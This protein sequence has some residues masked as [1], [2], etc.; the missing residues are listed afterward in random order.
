MNDLN[1][2]KNNEDGYGILIERDAGY[3]TREINN[4]NKILTESFEYNPEEPIL[5]NCILQKYG[6]PNRNGRI[7]PEKVLKKQVEAYNELV[8]NNS[9]VSE[10]DHPECVQVSDSQI[11]TKD[12]WKGF[13]EISDDENV[14]TL[15]TTTNKIEIQ[16]ISKKIYQ[17]YSGDMYKIN[18]R[19][20]EATLTPN[21]RIL[22]EKG[23]ERFYITVEELYHNKSILEGGKYKILKV[24]EW[25]YSHDDIFTLKGVGDDYLSYKSVKSH[26]ENFTKDLEIN[27]SDWFSFMGI[28]LADGH[29]GGTVCKKERNHGFDIVITQVKEDTKKEIEELLDRLPFEYKKIVYDF[30]KIQYHIRDARLYKYLYKLGSSHEKYI[31]YE[32]KNSSKENLLK[33]LEWFQKG[34]G[35]KIKLENNLIKNSIFSTSKQLMYDFREVLLKIGI[36]GNITTYTPKD[37]VIN[38]KKYVDGEIV[39]TERLIKAENSRLQYNLN[40]ST[41]KN[42]WIDKRGFKIEKIEVEDNMIGCVTT[43]NSNFYLM[44][45]GKAHW[46][47]NSTNI[48]LLNISH[49]ITKMWWGTNQDDKH[50]LYGQLRIIVSPGFLKYGIPTMIGDKIIVY[51]QHGIRIGI[52]SRGVGSLREEKGVFYVQDDFELVGF[53]LVATPS[54]F[55]AYLFPNKNQ[56]QMKENIIKNDTNIIIENKK[57]NAINNF[58]L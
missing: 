50:V 38:D 11:L 46:T 40:F 19:N 24:G 10:S 22:V 55:G 49:L 31:P 20:I 21:H 35:R 47:G 6:V 26:I 52:S 48:S 17:K 23:K 28:Y 13:D 36:S 16:Q 15:N 30:G 44:V 9:A 25:D 14:Y 33:L 57:I 1:I 41:T 4:K 7:Y 18:H 32:I 2:I 8:A 43:P 56:I 29:C 54:T 58:L 5:I 27:S 42:I 53:D 39:L 45:N 37:R 3:I 51:L 12:G 34:D